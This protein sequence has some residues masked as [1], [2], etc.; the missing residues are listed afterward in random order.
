MVWGP[1]ADKI[2]S[3]STSDGMANS[4]LHSLIGELFDI[5]NQRQGNQT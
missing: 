3:D 4:K 2:T 1:A 5:C